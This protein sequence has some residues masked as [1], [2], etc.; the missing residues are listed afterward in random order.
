[1]FCSHCGQQIPDTSAFCQFCGWKCAA[2]RPAPEAP[3]AAAPEA[4]PAAA[5]ETAPT[6]EELQTMGRGRAGTATAYAPSAYVPPEDASAARAPRRRMPRWAVGALCVLAGCVVIAVALGLILS[7]KNKEE[8]PASGSRSESS[9]AASAAS[10][11]SSPA[12]AASESDE[13]ELMEG[14]CLYVGHASYAEAEDVVLQFVLSAD[15]SSIHDVKIVITELNV[16]A[17]NG[18]NKTS[19]S[20]SKVTQTFS[21]EYDVSYDTVTDEIKLG[22]SALYN[23][24]FAGSGAAAELDFTFVYHGTSVGQGTSFPLGRATVEL[25]TESEPGASG[26]AEEQAEEPS[27]ETAFDTSLLKNWN[28]AALREAY[29]VGIDGFTPKSPV[30]RYYIVCADEVIDPVTGQISAGGYEK[31]YTRYKPID[32]QTLLQVSGELYNGGLILT[33]DPDKATYL[34]VLDFSYTGHIG[35]F[36]F[37]DNSV[38]KQYHPSL[39]ATLI[40]LVTGESL[41]SEHLLDYAT[42]SNERVYTAMLDAAKGKQFYGGAITLDA[43]DFEGYW[44]FVK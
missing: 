19:L 35:T 22:D 18:S 6:G 2:L 42:H 5:P 41:Q 32:T 4:A 16:T 40:D 13:A 34:L 8:T 3:P 29:G 14:E 37:K 43:E 28:D 1:M 7:P 27:T 33:D 25:T 23:L 44:D 30:P 9:S 26:Q 17:Q 31:N 11:S 12:Q 10:S 38:V 39:D 15:K 20:L 36:T 21:G 24:Q